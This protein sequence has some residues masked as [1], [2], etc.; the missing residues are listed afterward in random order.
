MFQP[1]F[2]RVLRGQ[3]SRSVNCPSCDIKW[4]V[5]T[6]PDEWPSPLLPNG[7]LW[8]HFRD[9]LPL[10]FG[11]IIWTFGDCVIGFLRRGGDWLVTITVL[12]LF[13]RTEEVWMFNFRKQLSANEDSDIVL[14][15][16]L[17]DQEKH[18]P[19]QIKSITINFFKDGEQIDFEISLCKWQLRSSQF[20][21]SKLSLKHYSANV[22]C[23]RTP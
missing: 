21:K 15:T 2:M 13:F 17:R 18:E 6:W 7:N 12:C 8:A 22:N 4:L 3:G 1:L 9:E 11:G 10:D 16:H 5:I 20:S 19:K 23:L 14:L